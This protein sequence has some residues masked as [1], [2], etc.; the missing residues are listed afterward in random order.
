MEIKD[1]RILIECPGC[2]GVNNINFYRG[3]GKHAKFVCKY[4][5]NT[6]SIYLVDYL[7]LMGETSRA[8]RVLIYENNLKINQQ[9]IQ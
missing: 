3:K 7:N 9:V 6:K 4:C 8:N 1:D 5:K 2:I